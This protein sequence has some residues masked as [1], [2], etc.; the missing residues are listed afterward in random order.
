VIGQIRRVGLVGGILV[1]IGSFL[2]LVS[3][4]FDRVITL[5]GTVLPW[6]LIGVL[7]LEGLSRLV[8]PADA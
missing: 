1:P 3:A 7:V 6:F 5:L 2:M 8:S 4:T